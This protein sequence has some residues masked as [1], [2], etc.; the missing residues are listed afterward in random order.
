VEEENVPMDSLQELSG[1]KVFNKSLFDLL[2]FIFVL[3]FGLCMMFYFDLTR[4]NSLAF[5]DT[6]I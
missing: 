4:T 5:K 2:Y 1:S 3:M 6:Q